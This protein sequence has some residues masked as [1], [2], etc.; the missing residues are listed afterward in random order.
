VSKTKFAILLLLAAAVVDS[1]DVFAQHHGGGSPGTGGVQERGRSPAD[2][3]MG[4]P[5]QVQLDQ[6]E[7]DLKLT[8]QQRSMWN[9]YADRVLSFADGMTRAQ[10]AARTATEATDATA[11]QQLD[12]LAD[13]ARQRLTAVEDIAE[14]G[15]ALYAMLSSDQKRIADHRLVLPI[16]PLANGLP[17]PGMGAAGNRIGR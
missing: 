11:A 3:N 10:F 15:K 8:P 14:S 9:A 1:P 4:A 13:R 6:L 12:Q 16:L 17:P 5:V 7:D 2:T